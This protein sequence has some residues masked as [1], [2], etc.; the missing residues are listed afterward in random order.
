M[1]TID[2]REAKES[3]EHRK[4]D[5]KEYFTLLKIPATIDLMDAGDFSFLDRHQEPETIERC[6]TGNL[7]EKVRSGELE[8]QLIRCA[9]QYSK[10]MLLHEGVVDELSSLL[11]TFKQGEKTYYR[12][13]I[14]P[15]TKYSEV[16]GLLCKLSEL[17]IEIF[18]TPNFDCSLTFIRIVYNQRRKPSEQSSLFVKSKGITIPARMSSNPAVPRLLS[19]CPRLSEKTAIRLVNKYG[20][21]WTILHTPDK[22]LLETDGF[23]STLLKRL[24]ENVGQ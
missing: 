23:G 14:Y 2:S 17:G 15:N 20:S 19:L 11:A 4:I 3:L 8:A 5:L 22:E 18:N 16:V 6:E 13:R 7:V 9:D 1:L 12:T 10:V 21:I 24:K